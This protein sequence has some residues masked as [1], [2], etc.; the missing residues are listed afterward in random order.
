MGNGARINKLS[1]SVLLDKS[2]TAAANGNE[3]EDLKKIQELV[4]AAIGIDS[5][6]GDLIS[7]QMLP[8]QKAPAVAP[9][10]W[11]E[12]YRDLIKLAIKYGGL[13]LV[14]LLLMLLVIRPAY[15]AI[16]IAAQPPPLPIIETPAL[17]PPAPLG[18]ESA[19]LSLSAGEMVMGKELEIGKDIEKEMEKEK[20]L[21]T[22]APAELTAGEEYSARDDD[23]TQHASNRENSS[24]TESNNGESTEY[25]STPEIAESEME[26]EENKEPLTVAEMAAE[27]AKLEVTGMAE[28]QIQAIQEASSLTKPLAL[29]TKAKV[30]VT[31]ERI[32]EYSKNEPEKAA[33]LIRHWLREK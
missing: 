23:E 33:L 32:I 7:V 9:L 27:V 31:R 22:D 28:Q 15:R 11:Y 3:A 18:A 19:A 16:R 5:T 30:S 26:S 29:E 1:V 8:F 6:R 17:L 24:K 2:Q 25:G 14:A 20:E 4:T 12:Q 10:P 13:A 21:N